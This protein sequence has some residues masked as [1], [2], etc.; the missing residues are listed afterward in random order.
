MFRKDD[1]D[2]AGVTLIA[3]NC[4][5][6]GDVHFTGQLLIN[7]AVKGNIQARASSGAIVTISEKGCVRGE[8]QAPN[9]VVNGKV[10]GNIRS[11]KYIEL[12]AKSE[13]KGNIH[14]NL[15]D[16]VKGSR[17][18]GELT[19]MQDGGQEAKGPMPSKVSEKP[20]STAGTGNVADTERNK[21]QVTA[22][23]AK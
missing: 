2:E 10:F 16:M 23:G 17:L 5:L 4:E 21:P 11:D 3:A 20:A 6:V 8:I 12:A 22:T 13:V 19:C 9:V 1:R 15:I 7:G 14:Y 18:N